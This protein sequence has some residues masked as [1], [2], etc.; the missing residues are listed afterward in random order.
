MQQ[1]MQ[2]A[3]KMQKQIETNKEQ[4]QNA[5]FTGE[6]GNGKVK[7]TMN[8][9]YETKNIKIDPE[10]INKEETD[11]LE[12]LITIAFNNCKQKIDEANKNSLGGLTGN[13][14][15]NSLF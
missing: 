14:N 15:L 10:L 7:V 9:L 5:N 13:M 6:S 2:Q 3:Q 8:G 12:D 1:L 4:M 11:I